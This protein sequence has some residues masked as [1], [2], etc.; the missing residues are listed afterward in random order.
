LA[1]EFQVGPELERRMNVSDNVY[2]ERF[3]CMCCF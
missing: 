3:D 2:L 1:E